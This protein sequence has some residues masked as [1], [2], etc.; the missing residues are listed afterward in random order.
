MTTKARTVQPKAMGTQALNAVFAVEY[1]G[2]TLHF[3]GG[4]YREVLGFKMMTKNVFKIKAANEQSGFADVTLPVQDFGVPSYEDLNDV[5]ETAIK[6]A[7]KKKLVL[8]GCGAGWGRTGTVLAAV[9]AVL[10]VED[11]V[12]RLRQV[13]VP[14]AVETP[15]Q[16]ELVGRFKHRP[17]KLRWWRLLAAL[18]LL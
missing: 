2:K 1:K 3:G 8:V 6:E 4:P 7:M 17:W 13:Y 11:P 5:V 15:A 16:R 10:G 12:T 9:L 18:D 14:Q